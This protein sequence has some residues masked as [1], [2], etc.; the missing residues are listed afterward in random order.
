MSKTNGYRAAIDWTDSKTVTV[1][2]TTYNPESTKTV[3]RRNKA[4]ATNEVCCST[5]I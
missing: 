2:S 3:P 4:H 1:L 5:T